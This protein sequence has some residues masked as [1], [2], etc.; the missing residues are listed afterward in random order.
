MGITLITY[1]GGLLL[2]K[3]HTRVSDEK[4]QI[5]R[6]QLCIFICALAV[7]GILFYFKYINFFYSSL[8]FVMLKLGIPI[9]PK[10]FD[11]VMP[12]GISFICFQTFGYVVDVSRRKTS[13]EKNIIHYALF[14]SF[15]PLVLSGPIERSTNL[16]RQI[17][18]PNPKINYDRF[19][20]GLILM[21]YGF[22]MKMVISDKLA[23][24]ANTV[25][26]NAAQ[27]SSF[28]LILGAAAF[29]F[30]IYCDFCGYSNI[31]IGAAQ[32]L[33]F[34]VIENFNT[35]YFSRSVREFWRRWHISLSTW[36][37]DYLYIPLGGNRCGKIRK[38]FNLLV[39]FLASGL[40]HGA[41]GHFI[42]WGGINWLYQVIESEAEAWFRKHPLPINTSAF[43]F[44]FLQVLTTW[45]L[46]TIA[47]IF[48]KASSVGAAL[49]Y[50]KGLFIDLS[51]HPLFDGTLF[52]LGLSRQ[53]LGIVVIAL[54][55]VLLV[56][57]IRYKWKQRIDQFLCTQN[58]WF[59]WAVLLILI[60]FVVV[61]GEYGTQYSSSD[62]IYL[63]F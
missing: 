6:Q 25:F 52:N 42:V 53:D 32:V 2:D 10:T 44:R 58:L 45:C 46:T 15:F 20:N 41:H 14:S 26:S 61:F 12:V 7:F 50:I 34:D 30:Q 28:V 5:V 16:L 48:F 36:F 1:A 3:I 38:Y 21:L 51:L 35:P 19:T 33:N 24:F 37:R 47:W 29:S 27:Y 23:I 39:T 63:Q 60:A 57:V 17:R 9:P 31:A 11:I 13:A 54:C 40:W 43:S 55:I 22:F 8:G 59:K 18:T 56:D 4:Q 62:F 49:R